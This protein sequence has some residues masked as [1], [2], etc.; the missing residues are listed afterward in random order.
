MTASRTE[1]PRRSAAPSARSIICRQA[2]GRMRSWTPW[3]AL[4]E[5]IDS[6]GLLVGDHHRER[7]LLHRLPGGERRVVHHE[8]VLPAEGDAGRGDACDR[9]PGGLLRGW[10]A[11]AVHVDDDREVVV[12]RVQVLLADD[13]C[14]LELVDHE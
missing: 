1:G 3:R 14:E 10:R 2:S 8:E 9:V 5:N 6:R 12:A 4:R 11:L 13:H 7:G